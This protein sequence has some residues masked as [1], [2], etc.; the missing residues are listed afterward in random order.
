M[1]QLFV[2]SKLMKSSQK[3]IC[4]LSTIIVYLHLFFNSLKCMSHYITSL[5]QL[6]I[7]P[8]FNAA[9]PS[10]LHKILKT[11]KFPVNRDSIQS[12][13]QCKTAF[14]SLQILQFQLYLSPKKNSWQL[15]NYMDEH[16][17]RDAISLCP[18]VKYTWLIGAG[19]AGIGLSRCMWWKN[20][21]E[22]DWDINPEWVEVETN[23]FVRAVGVFLLYSDVSFS[24]SVTA[25]V[26]FS[27]LSRQ[28]NFQKKVCGEV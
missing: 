26:M 17:K 7:P 27:S 3:I 9:I 4:P 28:L 2:L 25:A 15:S 14:A 11:T 12:T 8:L 18:F 6:K 20:P 22:I 19:V 21:E 5:H 1:W 13:V 16:I 10:F 24:S 23:R